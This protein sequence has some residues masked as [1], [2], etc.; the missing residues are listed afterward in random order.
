M[1]FDGTAGDS[2]YADEEN[3]VESDHDPIHDV[4]WW[5]EPGEEDDEEMSLLNSLGWLMFVAML[6]FSFVPL[7]LEERLGRGRML[8]RKPIK[9]IH[10]PKP[11]MRMRSVRVFNDL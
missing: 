11:A 7:M 8:A 4:G 5:N 3:E 6:C 1:L 2:G 9:P 10:D